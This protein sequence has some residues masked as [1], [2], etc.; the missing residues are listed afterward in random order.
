MARKITNAMLDAIRARRD[1]KDA[2]TRVETCRRE[3]GK[4]LAR[5]YLHGNHIATIGYNENGAPVSCSVSD[6]GWPTRTTVDRLHAIASTLAPGARV[7]LCKGETIVTKP[8]GDCW[9]PPGR[10]VWQT[11]ELAGGTA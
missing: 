9:R 4:P 11:I 5:V 6:A 2:N 3:D 8:G 1:W 7:N 10:I